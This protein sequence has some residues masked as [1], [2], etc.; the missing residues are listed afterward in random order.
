LVFD[1]RQPEAFRDPADGSL[2][3][4]ETHRA[5]WVLLEHERLY[6][7]MRSVAVLYRLTG[8][9]QYSDWVA[10]G[11]LGAADF[12]Q[13]A[14]R[15]GR[16]GTVYFQPLY[17][18]QVITLLA[19]AYDLIRDS[20]S[21]E[22]WAHEH[23]RKALF[24]SGSSGL[25]KYL[26]GARAHNIT[27]YVAAAVGTLGAILDE[28]DLLWMALSEEETGLQGLL[29][30]GLR[31]DGQGRTDGTWYEGTT[32][33]HLYAMCPLFCLYELAKRWGL[34]GAALS[35]IHDALIAMARVPVLLADERLRLPWLGDLGFPEHPGLT[36][37]AHLYEYAA[38]MLDRTFLA[39]LRACEA[40]QGRAGLAALSFGPDRLSSPLRHEPS[41]LLGQGGI[42]VLRAATR[43]GH[44]YALLKA[45]THGGGHDHRDK[46]QVV[47][48]AMG[49][50]I[51]PDLGTAGYSL[52]DFKL[53]CA[54]TLAHNALLV[55]ELDQSPVADAGV[56][57]D[58][59]S[60]ASGVVRD[61]YPGVCLER[62]VMLDPPRILVDD[63]FSSAAGH[64]YCWVFHA[65][66]KLDVEVHRA[67]TPLELPPLPC[68]G[69]F[70]FFRSRV[71]MGTVRRASARW[72]IRRDLSLLCDV[73]WDGPFECTI[74]TTPSNPMT[75]SLGTM[76]LRCPGRRRRARAAFRLAFH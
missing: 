56:S 38:G 40:G 35:E 48:H 13:H 26:R 32:F 68:E 16:Y 71:E 34:D 20:W 37:F 54:S 60:S 4:G 10:E 45:G 17:D 73:R 67:R 52:E 53:Y 59:A 11:I 57:M 7:L 33:Y 49:E 47:F 24:Q 55:D 61:A 31:R 6:R 39:V 22:A 5:A 36:S 74:G 46:L 23:I 25:L 43:R 51:A 44:Y 28:P 29:R 18:A 2:V 70:R 64:R 66:G 50:V 12:F 8:K 15:R 75:S 41:S 14:E 9:Q 1:P 19:N 76:F 63:A 65:K 3:T 62:R 21:L 69:P 42:A 72:T 58:S 27:C 30:K